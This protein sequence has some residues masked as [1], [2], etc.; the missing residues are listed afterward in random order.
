V[1]AL[2]A[3][4]D[5]LFKRLKEKEGK[6]NGDDGILKRLEASR[7]D[8]DPVVEYYAKRHKLQMIP[9]DDTPQG[10]AQ[11]WDRKLIR[12]RLCADHGRHSKRCGRVVLLLCWRSYLKSE[13]W[14]P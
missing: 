2:D 5:I 12:S 11:V 9:C 1:L 10:M 14:V 8:V 7:R 3:P 13:I 4:E 6:K